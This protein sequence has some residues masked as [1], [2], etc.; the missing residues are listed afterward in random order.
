M[1]DYWKNAGKES[2]LGELDK[3]KDA[4]GY[5]LVNPDILAR[6]AE[7]LRANDKNN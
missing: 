3:L 5:V 2:V 7:L 6:A 4:K 1:S